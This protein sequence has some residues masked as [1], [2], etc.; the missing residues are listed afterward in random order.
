MP[1]INTRRLLIALLPPCQL[2]PI[3]GDPVV[4]MEK[5]RIP[6]PSPEWLAQASAPI[7]PDIPAE[8][9]ALG[10]AALAADQNGERQQA[11]VL[12]QKQLEPSRMERRASGV[13][14]RCR[15]TGLWRD[16]SLAAL[17][18]SGRSAEASNDENDPLTQ[19]L[20]FSRADSRVGGCGDPCLGH[21]SQ[22]S[23]VTICPA[24]SSTTRPSTARRWSVAGELRCGP[25]NEEGL[26]FWIDGD[27]FCHRPAL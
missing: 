5:T 12:Q 23:T 19:L 27:V 8:V 2:A 15:E 22:K 24:L 16:Q 10:E 17:E 14:L 25:I 3:G 26:R 11:V 21:A 6:A 13:V 7:L 9:Q 18:R 1:R 4:A 20:Q